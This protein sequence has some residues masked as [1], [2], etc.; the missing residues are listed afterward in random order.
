[1]KQS[2]L[3][4][5]LFILVGTSCSNENKLEEKLIPKEKM[6]LILT[7]LML[8]EA[9]YNMQL[10]RLEDKDERMLKYSDEILDHHNVSR[11]SFDYSYDYY[12]A[13]SEE[14]EATFELVFEELS[15]LETESLKFQQKALEN[16]STLVSDSLSKN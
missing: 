7:D 8:L 13:H 5:L 3:I 11:E 12:M 15:K 10:V 4:L 16:D 9:T 2:I 14:F 1:M 6:A